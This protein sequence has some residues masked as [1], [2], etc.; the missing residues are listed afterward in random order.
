M[1]PFR[2]QA[3]TVVSSHWKI[4]FIMCFNMW[5]FGECVHHGFQF[6]S[7]VVQLMETGNL[8]TCQTWGKPLKKKTRE[9]FYLAK[10]IFWISTLREKNE[11][12][13]VKHWHKQ[14]I[15]FY[16]FNWKVNFTKGPAGIKYHIYWFSAPLP[17]FILWRLPVTRFA[18]RA[19]CIMLNALWDKQN[20]GTHML[21]PLVRCFCLE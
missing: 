19:T 12:L 14:L 16:F 3:L 17:V 6:F 11:Y 9:I 15:Y 20:Q 7:R 5:D 13:W 10:Y 8:D 4:L 18:H 21:F 2:Y 1:L